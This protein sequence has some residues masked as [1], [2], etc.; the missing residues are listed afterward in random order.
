MTRRIALLVLVVVLV[1]AVL[2]P[3]VFGART[4]SLLEAESAAMRELLAP[5]VE[6]ELGF[7]DWDVGWFSSTATVVLGLQ[8]AEGAE[9]PFDVP[10]LPESFRLTLPEAFTL[11][12]GPFTTS[13]SPGLRWG[14]MEMVIDDAVVPELLAFQEAVG[15]DHVVH[16]ALSVGFLGGTSVGMSVPPFRSVAD[17][18]T[19]N[20]EVAFAG[21]DS[22]LTFARSGVSGSFEGEMAGFELTGPVDQLVDVD[23][24]A[25]DGRLRVDEGLPGLTLG[26]GVLTVSGVRVTTGA[27]GVD[28]VL[29]DLRAEGVS[30]IDGDLFVGNN[31]VDIRALQ[32]DGTRFDDVV[33]E[34][35]ASMDA[36]AL[37]RFMADAYNIRPDDPAS[38]M[39]AVNML[40]NH[41]LTFRIDRLALRHQDRSASASLALDFRG[42]ELGDGFAVGSAMDVAS[43]VAAM[44]I[45]FSMTVHRDLFD[46]L[47]IDAGTSLLRAL[48]EQGFALESGDDYTLTAT[49]EGGVLTVNGNPLELFQLLGL[50]GGV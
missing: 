35:S 17:E 28:T 39:E 1:A 42:T 27:N 45:E 34:L 12:H 30:E 9:F 19:W 8:F 4:R 48:A 37:N 18:P 5:Q 20:L 26:G 44:S 32:I 2:L 11:R 22:T 10:N 13:P 33:L 16:L 6:F 38:Q 46:G 40:V 50:L 14:S 41:D 7:E 43:L 21:L 49:F 24:V 15:I 3:P 25:W 29:E 36:Q 47:G 23:R 31:R